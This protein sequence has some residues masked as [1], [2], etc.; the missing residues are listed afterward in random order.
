MRPR[1]RRARSRT[2]SPAASGVARS[3]AIWSPFSVTVTM[4]VEHDGQGV[5]GTA[6]GG[7]ADH[8]GSAGVAV[9][10]TG[11]EELDGDLG[12]GPGAGR[13]VVRGSIDVQDRVQVRVERGQDR[14]S[15]QR[16]LIQRF[17]PAL[18]EEESWPEPV[19][20]DQALGSCRE[21][22]AV[23]GGQ[24]LLVPAGDWQGD[25]RAFAVLQDAEHPPDEGRV[26]ERHV[27]GADERDVG[28]PGQRR[29]PGGDTLHRALALLRIVGN[30]GA[31]RQLRK[32][33]AGSTDDHD[34]PARRPGP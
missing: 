25:I 32:V 15:S 1:W 27:D 28:A 13:D 18:A 7:G 20:L 34:R 24:R 14:I 29:Q 6:H 16:R 9:A 26:Q 30:Q 33:L 11:P 23:G 3:L 2:M 21:R 8:A 31:F 19:L 5:G 4:P 10:R 22:D 12:G 17:H